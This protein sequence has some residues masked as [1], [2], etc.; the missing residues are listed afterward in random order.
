MK[1]ICKTFISTALLS[2]ALMTTAVSAAT[3]QFHFTGQY[4]LI[5][6]IGSYMDQTPIESTLTYDSN[7]GTGFSAAMDGR[8]GYRSHQES[9]FAFKANKKYNGLRTWA[10]AQGSVVIEWPQETENELARGLSW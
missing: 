2:S 9:C 1:G 5:D 3:F 8:S 7:S 10:L 4:T 6:S